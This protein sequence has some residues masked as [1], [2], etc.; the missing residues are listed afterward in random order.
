MNKFDVGSGKEVSW[1]N[2]A[3]YLKKQGPLQ[4][5]LLITNSAVQN[6][7]CDMYVSVFGAESSPQIAPPL[8]VHARGI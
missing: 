7:S 5:I 4:P 8:V 3:M 2:N 6:T 1:G